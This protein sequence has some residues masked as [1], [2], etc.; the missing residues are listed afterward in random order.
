MYTFL[1]VSSLYPFWIY[2]FLYHLIYFLCF[3]AF[4]MPKNVASLDIDAKQMVGLKR[5]SA[6]CPVYFVRVR[7]AVSVV[8]E[9]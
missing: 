8:P 3:I 7:S 4:T 2:F 1:I 9:F 5:L 6:I